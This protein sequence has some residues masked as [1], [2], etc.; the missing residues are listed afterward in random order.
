MEDKKY[1]ILKDIKL[2]NGSSIKKGTFVYNIQGVYFMDGGMLPQAY[3]EDFDELIKTEEKTGWKYI[4]PVH[5]RE[6]FK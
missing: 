3:Q 4:T 1:E 5:E 6:A 2:T